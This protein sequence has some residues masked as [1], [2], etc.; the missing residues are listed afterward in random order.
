MTW[1]D[2]GTLSCP[3][4]LTHSPGTGVDT[5]G[6]EATELAREAGLILDDWQ[7]WYLDGALAFRSDRKW[8]AFENGLDV[9]RQDGKGSIIETRCLAGLDLLDEKLLTY[10]AHE[11]KTAQEHFHRI[12]FLV[13]NCDRLRRKVKRVRKAAGAEAIEMLDGTR[14]RFLARSAGSGRGFSG[15]VV[16]FDEAMILWAAAVGALLPT[17]AART[18]VT[19]GGPQLWYTGTA[20]HGEAARVFASVRDRAIAGNDE[21]LFYAGWEAGEADDHT[22]ED[23]DLDDRAEWYRANP[24]MHGPNPRITEEFVQ[25]ERNALTDDEFARERLCIWGGA[26]MRSAIDPDTWLALT[27]A[28]SKPRGPIALAV[29]VPPEGKRASIARAGERADGR[30]HGEVDTR[31]GTGWAVERLAEISKKRNAVVVLDGGSRAMSLVP[32]LIKAGVE[33]VIYGTRD[34][35]AACGAFVDKVDEDKFRHMGQTELNLAVDA[36]RRRKV[37]D[38]WAWHR[39]DTSADISPLVATTLAVHGLKE[40]PPRRKTG[41]SMAV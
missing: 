24:A 35:V 39:R 27:D 11:F 15:D 10:T 2:V 29:D 1:R 20:G 5:L 28:K 18:N 21:G 37:G 6:P 38:A 36:A 12:T 17:M 41:R 30:V 25:K 4:R 23:V 19:A 3:P 26:G 13:E 9:P 7:A 34:V 16:F 33:P 40:E 32:A 31:P 14:L 22:G 8:A